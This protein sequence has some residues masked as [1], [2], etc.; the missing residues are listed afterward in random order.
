MGRQCKEDT[1]AEAR[2]SAA[3]WKKTEKK[4]PR[5]DTG[6]ADIL[7]RRAWIVDVVSGRTSRMKP[8]VSFASERG[9]G[10]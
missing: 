4:S 9:R 8:F 2:H 1:G 10:P 7:S 3:N 6:D 5:I